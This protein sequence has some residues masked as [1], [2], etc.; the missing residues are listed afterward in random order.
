MEAEVLIYPN[1]HLDT[2]QVTSTTI[3]ARIIQFLRVF[4][5]SL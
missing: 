5:I 4:E 3:N 2:F 1:L